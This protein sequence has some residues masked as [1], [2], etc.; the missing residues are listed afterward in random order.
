MNFYIFFA[1]QNKSRKRVAQAA[2][3]KP[4]HTLRP[5]HAAPGC[6]DC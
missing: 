4:K 6:P 3:A 2:R 1:V 5:N